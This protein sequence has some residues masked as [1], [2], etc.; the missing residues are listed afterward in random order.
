MVILLIGGECSLMN[1]LIDKFNKDKHRV[2]LI[3]GKR[4]RTH[5][6]HKVFEKY[7]FPY[8]CDGIKEIFEST[9]PDVV[10][11]LGAYDTNYDWSQARKESVRFTSDLTNILSAFCGSR[12]GRFVYLSSQ[13]VYG[14]SYLDDV[15]EEEPV[16]AKS[17]KAMAVSQGETICKSYRDTRSV[18]TAIL[19]LDHL[20]GIPQKDKI[21]E[22]PCFEM[23]LAA[24]KT[25]K[26][27]ANSR[28]EFSMIYQSDAVEF[29]AQ[30][31]TAGDLDHGLYHISSGKK[32]TQA[33]LADLVKE[34]LGDSCEIHDDTVGMGYRLLLDGSRYKKEFGQTIFVDYKTGV[35][36][37]VQYMKRHEDAFLKAGTDEKQGIGIWYTMKSIIRLLIPYAENMICFIPF[38]MLNNR[39]VGSQ[40]FNKLDFYLLYVLLFAIVYGQQQAIFSSLLATAGYCFRQM[41]DQ[42]GFEVL[43]NYNT[44][45]WMAQLF[46]LGMVVGYMRDRIHFVK[47]QDEEEIGYLSG[48]LDDMADINDS[49]VRMKH[50]FESQIVN[51]KDSLGKIYEITSALDQYGPEEVL[52][53]AA[54][55]LSKLMESEDVALYTVAN[56]RYARLFSFTSETARRLGNSIEYVEMQEMY[57]DLKEHRVY[58]NKTLHE[59]YP[60][61]AN[62]IY[63]GE[64]MQIILMIWGIPWE[65]MNL[66]EANR[67]TVVG[68]LIQNAVVRANRY[69]NA[70][71]DQRYVEGTNILDTEAFTLLVH[72]F[73]EAKRNGLTECSLV[74][75]DVD[76]KFEKR[77][78]KISALLRQTDYIGT[79]EDGLYVLLPNTDR[80]NAFYVIARISEIGYDSHVVTGEVTGC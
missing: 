48:Q 27:A 5:G 4:E 46:I 19:R 35:K 55:I 26:I 42:S 43:L 20:Y 24:L 18:E 32:I 14:R 74:K 39:A 73:E 79:M 69:L 37:V 72:A 31:V 38:F 77:G 15:R 44:Y 67:L 70:L 71:K 62:A 41:Y 40:Y 34:N 54:K 8:N 80:K 21:E 13:E 3:T 7:N 1:A 36:K 17:F 6:Y 9:Q 76:K 56:R 11:D 2:Y 12:K 58:I 47:N 23:I 65:R 66:S 30:L 25:K 50:T 49:N 59:G 57:D 16:S 10:I 64:E 33:E 29:I 45:V 61:M 52:F 68:Y 78:K 60:L 28:N 22:N 51:H 63:E 75:I 53:Y